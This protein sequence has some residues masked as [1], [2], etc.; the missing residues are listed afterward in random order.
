[1][2]QHSGSVGVSGQDPDR[3]AALNQKGFVVFQVFEARNDL[4]ERFPIPGRLA[5]PTV[6]DEILRTFGDIRIEIVHEHPQGG[7]LNPAFTP[8]LISFRGANDSRSHIWSPFTQRSRPTAPSTEE[9]S[10]PEERSP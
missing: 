7:F 3:L 10:D 6:Y 2:Q 4:V 9:R 8:K 5:D 1:R